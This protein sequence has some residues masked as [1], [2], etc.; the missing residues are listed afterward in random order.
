MHFFQQY[1]LCFT[2]SY[3]NDSLLADTIREMISHL[4][5]DDPHAI[6]AQTIARITF[7]IY[8]EVSRHLMAINRRSAL[9]EMWLAGF[10]PASGRDRL[11]RFSWQYP[12]AK[13]SPL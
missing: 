6:D 3:L 7:Q 10:C 8:Q 2:G 11:F 5:L 4:V 13:Y 9:T 12:S 1:G